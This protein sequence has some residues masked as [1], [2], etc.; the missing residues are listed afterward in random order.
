MRFSV[1]S[2]CDCSDR[3]FWFDFS[4]PYAYFASE[5]LD[6]FALDTGRT[7][8]WRPFLLGAVMTTTGMKPLVDMPMRGD[9][10]RH[11]WDRI[12]RVLNVPFALPAKH[13]YAAIKASR[14][15]YWLE[16]DQPDRTAD[17]A[18]AIFGAHFAEGR[19]PS[20]SSV[21][22]NCA[23][24]IDID[25]AALIEQVNREDLW[26]EAAHALGVASADIPASTSRGVETLFDGKVYLEMWIKVK[27]IVRSL[28]A[29][30]FET[31]VEAVGKA[32]T[33]VT[34]ADC[35]GYFANCNYATSLLQ[36]Q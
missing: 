18:H 30:T 29:R 1:P 19:D 14:A 33:A 20:E 21:I 22:A 2:S 17:F 7:V 10:A 3:K 27:S 13:P 5:S 8:L 31:I 6:Q 25:S 23:N 16:R 9:Y 24:R 11:D 36:M 28:D 4:S 32:I 12:A 26:R 15:Y 35:L 34:P